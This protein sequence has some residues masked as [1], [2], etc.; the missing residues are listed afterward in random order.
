MVKTFDEIQQQTRGFMVSRIIL[1]A[2]E[3]DLFS[4]LGTRKLT[5]EQI[6]KILKTNLRSTDILL[7]ALAGLGYLKKVHTRFGNTPISKNYLV[8]SSDSYRGG[9]LR[10]HLN[11]W[12]TWSQ[13]T[14]VMRSGKPFRT[15]VDRRS[16]AIAGRDFI[17]GMYHAGWETAKHIASILDLTK[18][19]R[20]L[21]LGGGPG[22]YAIAFAQKNPKLTAVVFD[23]PYALKVTQEIITKYKLQTRIK[24]QPG[25]FLKNELGKNYDMVL[26][27]QIIHS[28]ST[29]QNLQ[30]LKKVYT[31]LFPG[32]RIVLHDFL[33]D[34]SRT[35]PESAAI[36]AI[37]M[38]VNTETGRTY[39]RQEVSLWLKQVGFRG[40]KLISVSPASSILIGTK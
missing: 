8:K 22:S 24:L 10:H 30:V 36:F 26:M 23:L 21:D 15:E 35:K 19:N 33:L 16:D 20:F 3:F 27:S 2:I 11:L 6:A 5:V 18:V 14:T 12:H 29:Q 37:N 38:L 1:T 7:H 4:K 40:I 13:L 31:S 39:S 34:R 17:W 25:D 32:G 28:Y 9:I